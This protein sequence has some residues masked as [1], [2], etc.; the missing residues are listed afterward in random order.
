[1]FFEHHGMAS[2]KDS[3]NT[4]DKKIKGKTNGDT[5][6]ARNGADHL[7]NFQQQPASDPSSPSPSSPFRGRLVG[8]AASTSL[9]TPPGVGRRPRAACPPARDLLGFPTVGTTHVVGVGGLRGGAPPPPP[10][11]RRGRGGGGLPEAARRR[12]S[13]AP[14]GRLL[15]GGGRPG[16]P[17]SPRRRRGGE[18]GPFV[19]LRYP[20]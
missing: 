3:D 12:S 19:Q 2:A 4:V 18:L 15:R 7:P 20:G 16:A 1:M 11:R 5:G 14:R 13:P 8:L 9:S 6:G 10:P 17:A